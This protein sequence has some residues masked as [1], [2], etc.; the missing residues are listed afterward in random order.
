MID[1][2][3]VGNILVDPQLLFAKDIDD[4]NKNVKQLTHFTNERFLP[5]ILLEIEVVKSLSEVR[6]NKPEFMIDLSDIDFIT[7]KWGKRILNIA[8]GE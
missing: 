8:I 6:R 3:V 4:W 2:I 5:K 7:I 1:N